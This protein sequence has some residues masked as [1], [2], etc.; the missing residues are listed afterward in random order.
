MY[1]LVHQSK[2]AIQGLD[3]YTMCKL[4]YWRDNACV[5][6]V[7]GT[8]NGALYFLYG[9]PWLSSLEI[10]TSLSLWYAVTQHGNIHS[11][12]RHA[13]SDSTYYLTENS[14]YDSTPVP[15]VLTIQRRQEEMC[16]NITIFSDTLIETNETLTVTLSTLST[17]FS[18]GVTLV[19]DTATIQIVDSDGE[20]SFK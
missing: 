20:Q 12:T 2:H 10:V 14:D 8:W 9:F 5:K 4:L 7:L 18:A 15:S 16:S 11:L 6:S 1:S 19:P 13:Y 17:N 3:I